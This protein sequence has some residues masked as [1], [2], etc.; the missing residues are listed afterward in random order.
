M[1][2]TGEN[3]AHVRLDR[4]G[5]SYHL[6]KLAGAVARVRTVCGRQL[7]PRQTVNLDEL[8]TLRGEVCG[9]CMRASYVLRARRGE[10][11]SR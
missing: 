4:D 11:V 2:W 10:A 5:V 8:D 1:I 7:H 9:G 3:P 6:V